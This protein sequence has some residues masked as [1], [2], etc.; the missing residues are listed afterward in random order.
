MSQHRS[1]RVQ[2]AKIA[3]CGMVTALS[4][5]LLLTSSI[6]PIMTYAAP[7]LCGLLLVPVQ[8]E[9]NRRSAFLTFLATAIL[10][11]ILGF[12]KELA[13]F[14]LFLGY[15]P[16]VKWSFDRKKKPWSTLLKLAFFSFALLAMYAFL[17]YVLHVTAVVADFEDMGRVMTFFFFILMVICL[18]LFDRLITPLTILYVTRY[19]PKLRKFLHL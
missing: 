18:M 17:T 19:Q 3:L 14:Y 8:L 1:S 4:V 2:S 10:T 16:L 13:F 6:I 7:L 12:D 9:F 11:L 15:Y 5:V